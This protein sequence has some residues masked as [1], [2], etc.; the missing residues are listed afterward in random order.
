[1]K[2]TYHYSFSFGG[3]AYRDSGIVQLSYQIVD[4]ETYNTLREYIVEKHNLTVY[5]VPMLPSSLTLTSLTLVGQVPGLG[6]C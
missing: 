4:D 6:L 3:G 1:M 5:G 2:Y